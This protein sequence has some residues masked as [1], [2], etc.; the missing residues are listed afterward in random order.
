M[1]VKSLEIY[2]EDIL[3]KTLLYVKLSTL[4]IGKNV[5]FFLRNNTSAVSVILF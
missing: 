2:Q 4:K 1:L 5:A 3:I